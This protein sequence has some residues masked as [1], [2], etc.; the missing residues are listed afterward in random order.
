M[1]Q[2]RPLSMQP[3]TPG[4]GVVVRDGEKALVGCPP[5]LVIVM[6]PVY[7]EE[8]GRSLADLGLSPELVAV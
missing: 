7:L 6:N 2:L 1:R 3:E 4:G 5:D 8:I